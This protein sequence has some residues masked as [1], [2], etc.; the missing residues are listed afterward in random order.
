MTLDKSHPSLGLK[1]HGLRGPGDHPDLRVDCEEGGGKR[2]LS[3][4]RDTEDGRGSSPYSGLAEREGGWQQN[5]LCSWSGKAERGEPPFKTTHCSLAL[6]AGGWGGAG[7][8]PAC[9]VQECRGLLG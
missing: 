8:L 9:G 5:S 4:G 6:Q 3:E 7:P 1:Y 2:G